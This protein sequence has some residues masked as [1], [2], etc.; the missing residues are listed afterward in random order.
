MLSEYRWAII[1][2]AA[3]ILF[4]LYLHLIAAGS[5][6]QFES[7]TWLKSFNLHKDIYPYNIRPFQTYSTILFHQISGF[8]LKESF[9]VIQYLLAFL[10]GLL[11][12]NFLRKLEFSPNWALCGV[13]LLMLS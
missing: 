2:V 10:I 11:F 9:Y 13:S 5:P 3:G 1:Y 7:A 4:S 12:Y 8:P 6:L